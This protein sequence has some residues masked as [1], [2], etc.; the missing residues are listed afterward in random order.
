M[1]SWHLLVITNVRFSDDK[2]LLNMTVFGYSNLKGVNAH[3]FVDYSH[4]I[5]TTQKIQMF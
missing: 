4:A 5:S 1:L 2:P 3:K